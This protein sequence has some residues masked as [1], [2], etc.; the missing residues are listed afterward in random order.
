[1]HIKIQSQ[2]PLEVTEVARALL[3]TR[4]ITNCCQTDTRVLKRLY[5]I[6]PLS[7]WYTV[8]EVDLVLVSLGNRSLYHWWFHIANFFN[9]KISRVFLLL[10][11]LDSHHNACKTIENKTRRQ[12]ATR[13]STANISFLLKR[14]HGSSSVASNGWQEMK[15]P[16]W[17]LS[18]IYAY[19]HMHTSPKLLTHYRDMRNT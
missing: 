6:S 1:M 12:H 10:Y 19:L 17:N 7:G 9:N 18:R 3:I 13:Q 4:D 16:G 2:R 14:L 15:L 11:S 8:R 5:G